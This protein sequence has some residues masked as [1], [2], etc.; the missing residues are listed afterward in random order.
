MERKRLLGY[1]NLDTREWTD[2][3][4]TAAARKV[5]KNAGNSWVVC[6]GDID[7]EW[8]EALNSVLDDNRLLTMPSGE[9]IQFDN[10][11]NFIFE[12]DDL[13]FASPATVS[14]MGQLTILENVTSSMHNC[15][16]V[17]DF[18]VRLFRSLIPFLPAQ[19]LFEFATTIVFNGSALHDPKNPWN[20]CYDDRIDSL[21]SYTDDLGIE[22]KEEDIR[23]GQ[24]IPLILT[25]AVQAKAETI[26]T[27]LKEGSRK[28][29][30]IIGTDGVGK[31]NL[32]KYCLENDG[33]S[34]SVTIYCSAQTD[35]GHIEKVLFQH[36]LQVTSV[37][38]RTLKPKDKS[39][40]V[41][42]LKGLNLA[43]TDKY[44]SSCMVS[45]LHGILTYQGYYDE[46]CEW[47]SLENIQLIVSVTS[48]K[49]T[50]GNSQLAKRFLS[51][52]RTVVLDGLKEEELITIYSEIMKPVLMTSLQSSSKIESVAGSITRIFMEVKE[53]FTQA[54][55]IHYVF[56]PKDLTYW[57]LNLLR[58]M[59][60]EENIASLM[61]AAL[62]Y[63]CLKIFKDRLISPDH[64]LHFDNIINDHL[65]KVGESRNA[66]F[67][68]SGNS[69]P[70]GKELQIISKRDYM[71]LIEKAVN[72]YQFEISNFKHV[73]HEEFLYLCL[74]V[75]R[76]LSRPQGSLLLCGQSGSGRLEAVSLVAHMQRMKVVSPRISS[77]YTIKQFFNDL[78][79]V[80]SSASIENESILFVLENHQ[81]INEAFLEVINSLLNS[82]MVPGLFTQQELDQLVSQL[83]DLCSQEG[84]TKDLYSFLA[85][86][87]KQNLHIVLILNIDNSNFTK[88]LTSNPALYKE[89][90]V[91]WKEGWSESTL[92]SIPNLI[93]SKK[94]FNSPTIDSIGSTFVTLFSMLEKTS[95]SPS[96]F[97]KFVHNFADIYNKKY[98]L[99][100]EKLKHLKAGIEKLT[101]T[102]NSVATLQKKA[103]TNS[104]KLVAK[105]LE[106]DK[107]LKAITESMSG[108][109]DQK[110]DMEQLKGDVEKENVR[111][112]K[113]KK[114]IEEQ[115]SEVEPLLKE[116]RRAVGSIK[117]ESLSEIRSL[118][119]PPEAI[120][121][122]LQAVLLFMG[123]L[124]TSWENMRKFLGKSGIKEE[125]INFDARKI[126]SGAGAKVNA[127]MKAKPNSFDEKSAK[128]ASVAAAPLAEWV[129]AN[130]QFAEIL[131]KIEPLEKE[132]ATL[133]KNLSKSEKQI[134]RLSKGLV[135]V[136][137]EVAELKENFERLVKETTQIK[138]DIDREQ[139]TIKA[140]E[141]LV[142][143]LDGEYVRWKEQNGSLQKESD[144]L[145]KQCLIGAAFVTFMGTCSEEQRKRMIDEWCDALSVTDFNLPKFLTTD[146]E[147]LNWKRNKLPEDQLSIENASIL[148]NSSDF[149]LIIDTTGRICTFLQSQLKDSNVEVINAGRSDLLLQIELGVRFGKTIIIDDVMDIEPGLVPLLRKQISS[150]GPRQIIQ[151]GNN[152]KIDYNPAFKLFMCTK[153]AQIKLP[154]YI[155]SIVN[156]V[157]FSTTKSGLT[158]QLLSLA[159]QIEKPKLDKRSSELTNEA[160]QMQMKLNELEGIL[161]DE[162][163]N[164]TGS[165]IENT[166]LLDSLKKL[167][168]NSDNITI[169]LK[170]SEHLQ[171]EL[172]EQ[173]N[174]FLEFS[175]KSSIL[176]FAI[177]NLYRQNTMYNFGVTTIMKLFKSVMEKNM[178][179]NTETALEGV[180]NDLRE[181]VFIYIS[182][183]LFKAD[184]L[185][186]SINYVHKTK[187][188][189]FGKN[190]WEFFIGSLA[191][192]EDG[193]DNNRTSSIQW[194][195]SIRSNS[196]AKLEK[197]LPGLVK[198]VQLSDQGTW[199]EF[200]K[201]VDAENY[202]PQSTS[203]KMTPFQ[204]VLI[205]QAIRPDR[206]HTF[207]NN[208]ACQALQLTSINPPPLDLE[209]IYQVDSTEHEPIL[210]LTGPGADPSQDLE[211]LGKRIV[212][213]EN[214]LQIS[215]GQGQQESAIQFLK[216]SAEQ[217]LWLCIKNVHLVSDFLPR[218]QK[219]LGMLT[220]HAKFR[221]W[222]TSEPDE[223]FPA[224]LAQESLKLT[225]ESPPGLE[226][227]MSRTYTQWLQTK[228]TNSTPIRLQSYFI[229]AF[230]HAMLQ[231]RRTYIPQAWS[232][233]Y[234]FSNGDLRASKL[235][236]ERIVNEADQ[237]GGQIDWKTLRGLM[238]FVVYGGR[239]QNSHDVEILL[240]YLNKF[241]SNIFINGST[242]GTLL[243]DL[244]MP[245][246][247]TLQ[248]YLNWIKKS[249]KNDGESQL[250]MLGLP[251]N[252]HSSW[253]ITSSSETIKQL[254]SLE[255]ETVN[256]NE[257]D[258]QEWSNNLKPI[259]NLWKSLNGSSSYHNCVIPQITT[260]TNPLDEA[261]K[262][263]FV[264]A[265]TLIQKI[266]FDLGQLSK[267]LKGTIIPTSSIIQLCKELMLLS[268]P[269]KWDNI[270]VGPWD[271]FVYLETVIAKTRSTEQI[272]NA[273][274]DVSLISIDLS[275]L[276]RPNR[277]LNAFRQLISRETNISMDQL[278]LAS[279]W[280]RNLL[281]E[282]KFCV[283]IK[284][285]NIEGALFD[286]G[287]LSE[288]LVT[289][290]PFNLV[291]S[292]YIS[293]IPITQKDIYPES[294]SI[295]AAIYENA[296]RESVVT[297][298]QLPFAN[299]IDKDKWTI[300]GVALFLKQSNV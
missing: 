241:F 5:V 45:Y 23:R 138:I 163:A 29:I 261:F 105:E 190:E 12:T 27:W 248:D 164:S 4:L 136:D 126:P 21:I 24:Q 40:L 228:L 286:S 178:G 271:P 220:P 207:L 122:I 184:R 250:R 118:R 254:R 87:V 215:M 59:I 117:S 300:T 240:A 88:L 278:K 185:M 171:E 182:R 157:N 90:T 249:I 80:I 115:L 83:R 180:Y 54:L 92:H 165:I 173:R 19:D 125:I 293:W 267:A 247:S 192:K 213:M 128:R 262:G 120:R 3:V 22:L 10:N 196:V 124:D 200:S 69:T 291:P 152:D 82:G 61:G 130:L 276:L 60:T 222:L 46:H 41:V 42:Y 238:A 9:R 48:I 174:I 279:A 72:R 26:N 148:F 50:D 289:S 78:K 193:Q 296:S 102:K 269:S 204:K 242:S 283:E 181:T 186:F 280:H 212:G 234:E 153:N 257:F 214:Y 66:L 252:I 158:A 231:E 20:V 129:K 275:N 43:K 47:I 76:V 277:F 236:T 227:N 58:Y 263:E 85:H 63:E 202:F 259:L 217:G 154:S 2:G 151:I 159:I 149:C 172:L 25:S 106:A 223:R 65:G 95:Q 179:N 36:C 258:K 110:A 295:N 245:N 32:I 75:D 44:G 30:L 199:K 35:P 8:I 28:P 109:T 74:S 121:D 38:G 170:E 226:N 166:Q 194:V 256:L 292:L 282:V 94:D 177:N 162:L 16:N 112:E 244:E 15:K 219:E 195:P 113:Q 274:L 141:D 143:R 299:E 203:T 237:N 52:L 96:K 229:V 206:L 260:H 103:A 243:R 270:W 53:R 37:N 140:A 233:F 6:D 111:I 56:T 119:A 81:M 49:T 7:P 167:K 68:S 253:E 156:E 123:I 225:F 86:K 272:M 134:E 189:L 108:A 197:A 64:R 127:L 55:C 62:V 208:F 39:N 168:E 284:N 268:V 145:E 169:A 265:L 17:N 51:M 155:S 264:F 135:S 133:L 77:N 71:M 142:H 144:Q 67:I 100:N 298:V 114:I 290:S 101:E 93:L 73:L 147:I 281:E 239:I 84:Y 89:C 107:A 224:V 218:L 18:R 146:T 150:Q 266:H 191:V 13:S 175:K 297:S 232:S 188:D 285:L 161:L 31:E 255:L 216:K 132:K 209:S 33:S 116:A 104:K 221:L 273:N 98:G 187:P 294:K 288:S 137:A 57:C 97:M 1:M 139:G 198:A 235:I 91:I 183:G 287:M 211:E 11:V 99:V 205:I 230:L 79:S 176:Y 246:F 34:N 70:V 201:A 14:R 210:I 131:Q 251:L 160:E